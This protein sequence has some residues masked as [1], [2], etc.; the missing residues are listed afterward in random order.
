MR[1]NR[2]LSL[3]LCSEEALYALL[4]SIVPHIVDLR[5]VKDK[6]T[7]APRNFAFVELA[8]IAD[9]GRLMLGVNNGATPEGQPTP[10][11]CVY[12]RRRESERGVVG[13]EEADAAAAGG[14]DPADASR[15]SG[16]A[17]ALAMAGWKPKE[18]DAAALLGGEEGQGGKGQVEQE[19]KGGE[20]G[21][22]AA[23][24]GGIGGGGAGGGARAAEAADTAARG[25][26]NGGG[27]AADGSR[28]T[29][30]HTGSQ[31]QQ[32][33]QHGYE[34]GG[35]LGLGASTPVGAQ[36]TQQQQQQGLV[37]HVIKSDPAAGD[38]SGAATGVG[39]QKPSQTD[40]IA[41]AEALE[42]AGFSYDLDTG[43]WFEPKTGYYYDA[44]TRLYYH[45]STQQWYQLDASTGQYSAVGV[46]GQSQ[47][48]QQQQAQPQQQQQEAIGPSL[49]QQ[50]G[51]VAAAAGAG[52]A[53]VGS[54]QQ[55]GPQQLQQ[56]QQGGELKKVIDRRRGAVI[57]ARAQY[58]PE[59][60]K[61]AQAAAAQVA[62]VSCQG[63]LGGQ[64]IVCCVPVVVALVLCG[65][66]VAGRLGF[67]SSCYGI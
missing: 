23:G 14:G 52:S 58:N 51:Q 46:G 49:Q 26:W 65:A 16:A 32:Q 4:S 13:G 25:Q 39:A 31:Q 15:G 22:A 40:L 19:G 36:N 10:L 9:A 34:G 66:V 17:A 29:A 3:S 64:H 8:S 57:G 67:C 41:Q 28:E 50:Q 37:V 62:K 7:G 1:I 59:G 56:Q 38:S 2:P 30:A 44:N 21:K 54:Q 33:Q 47:Q 24:V 48:E 43:Y 20:H 11:R 45:P 63:G 60:L 18:F 53:L 55:Q 27:A 42:A 61:A 12:A 6:Y 5:V 35:Q